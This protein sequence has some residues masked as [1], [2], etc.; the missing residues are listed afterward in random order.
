MARNGEISGAFTKH[1]KYERMWLKSLC[2]M[3]N[4]KVF[5]KLDRQITS[6]LKK[7]FTHYIHVHASRM[8]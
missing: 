2:V 1:G 8:D 6:Q 3:S 5:A 7:K 4:I